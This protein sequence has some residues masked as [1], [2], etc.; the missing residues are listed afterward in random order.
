MTVLLLVI[1]PD[2]CALFHLGPNAQCVK[3]DNAAK[4]KFV[5]QF[6]KK[7]KI[8]HAL[9]ITIFLIDYFTESCSLTVGPE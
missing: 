2:N 3:T 4:E 9:V 1:L 7:S 5:R 6:G 8:R